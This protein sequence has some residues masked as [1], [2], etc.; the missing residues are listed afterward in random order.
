MG[1]E[2]DREL[3]LIDLVD[4]LVASSIESQLTASVEIP[5]G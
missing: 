2:R 5:H 3:F 1:A 4:E